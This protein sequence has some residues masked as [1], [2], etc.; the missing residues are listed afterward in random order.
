MSGGGS[1]LTVLFVSSLLPATG[2]RPAPGRIETMTEW[3]VMRVPLAP[4]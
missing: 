1:I 2:P 4:R 3:I